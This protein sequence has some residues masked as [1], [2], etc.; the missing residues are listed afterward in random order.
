MHYATCELQR[1]S[2][3][4]TEVSRGIFSIKVR[5]RKSGAEAFLSSEQV[6]NK[7]NMSGGSLR[8]ML[9]FRFRQSN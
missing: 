7:H 6:M 4:C 9:E 3:N 1:R 2:N 5:C 8:H